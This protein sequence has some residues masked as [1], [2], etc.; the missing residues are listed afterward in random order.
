MK[1]P[2]R[3]LWI[4]VLVLLAT[5][6]VQ[7]AVRTLE[8]TG[9]VTETGT[10]FPPGQ[11]SFEVGDRYRATIVFDDSTRDTWAVRRD[12]GVFP[13]AILRFEIDFF[14]GDS[15]TLRNTRMV[16]TDGDIKVVDRFEPIFIP[17]Q[18]LGDY[19]SITFLSSNLYT[20]P[21]NSES[22]FLLDIVRQVSRFFNPLLNGIYIVSTPT[23]LELTIFHPQRHPFENTVNLLPFP[24][25]EGTLA[26]ALPPVA[27]GGK[28]DTA[29]LLRDFVSDPTNTT[30]DAAGSAYVLVGF[31]HAGVLYSYLMSIED[32]QET[33][34]APGVVSPCPR[35]QLF[36]AAVGDGGF[37]EALVGLPE[38]APAG[39]TLVDLVVPSGGITLNPAFILVPEGETE[40]RADLQVFLAPGGTP[41]ALSTHRIVAANAAFP[42][43]RPG[44]LLTI[45]SEVRPSLVSLEF[46]PPS[47]PGGNFVTGLITL[48]GPASSP[49]SLSLWADLNPA[50]LSNLPSSIL[51]MEG[52]NQA[53]FVF[54]TGA[55]SSEITHTV[56][57]FDGDTGDTASAALT[58]EPRANIPVLADLVLNPANVTGGASSTATVVLNSPAP[59]GGQIV[60]L[61]ASF[62]GSTAPSVVV[63]EGQTAVEFTV[64]TTAVTDLTP[65]PVVA[66]AGDE[67]LTRV[68][69]VF[70]VGQTPRPVLVSLVV[71]PR[72]LAGG[73][74]TMGL[75]E[76]NEATGA[77][78]FIDL[79][80]FSPFIGFPA[81]VVIAPGLQRQAFPIATARTTREIRAV[82]R[83]SLDGIEREAFVDL[84]PGSLPILTAVEVTHAAV[85]APFFQTVNV[86][87]DRPAPVGGDSFEFW[88]EPVAV[89]GPRQTVVLPQGQSQ[90]S[91]QRT[92][93]RGTHGSYVATLRAST[94]VN[95]VEAQVQVIDPEDRA[96]TPG[97]TDYLDWVASTFDPIAA[98]DP[99]VSGPTVVPPGAALPNL[100]RYLQLNDDGG[101]GVRFTAQPLAASP[102]GTGLFL[103]LDW[104]RA[105]I[106]YL[107]VIEGSNDL[108]SWLPLGPEA[109]RSAPPAGDD[110]S[111]RVRLILELQPSTPYRFFR[112]RPVMIET[113]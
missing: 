83:A 61:A 59:A 82:L 76:L 70:P 37:T 56:F 17:G 97:A 77:E 107:P 85:E 26:R 60:F 100:L 71:E 9:F 84:G 44:A 66:S 19:S 79:S 51:V 108:T 80:S 64:N 58:L 90:V 88:I 35:L 78:T 11:R 112:A 18:R 86:V 53:A 43:C 39:G 49:M 67:S 63:P 4:V 96:N 92:F 33:T 27:E 75:I 7:A 94:G 101:S 16:A 113:P 69:G 15:T 89:Y 46:L 30:D 23:G 74:P 81:T 55:V 40:A 57:A 8:F 95:Q 87:F 45:E 91:L 47:V 41:S 62:P 105:A 21:T 50:E 6:A 10:P 25:V 52:Q 111:D 34:P 1:S 68:L 38:P 99:A 109:F 20:P 103:E 12:T 31:T 28:P 36:I 5:P 32:I 98:A 3:F 54:P 104:N 13:G 22:I 24:P 65:V 93:L 48:D 29:Q 73:L 42:N 72:A 102:G 110:G 106:D 2:L 14:V